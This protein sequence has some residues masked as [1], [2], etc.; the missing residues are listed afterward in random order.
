MTVALLDFSSDNVFFL[1]V[2]VSV[3]S[4]LGAMVVSGSI[5]DGVS[6]MDLSL[7]FAAFF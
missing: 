5:F 2:I 1:P 4:K 7:Y 6:A 3:N